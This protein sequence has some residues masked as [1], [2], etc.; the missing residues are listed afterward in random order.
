MET[1]QAIL[2]RRSIRAYE[3]R[4]IPDEELKAILEAGL[5]APSGTNLQPWYFAAIRSPEQMKTLTDIMSGVANKIEPN[6]RQRFAKNPAVVEETTAFVRRLG[7]APVC[8]LVFEYKPHYDNIANII[9]LSLGAAMEN[10]LLA[11]ADR[12]IGG[13]WLTAP[14]EAEVGTLLQETFA[15]GKGPLV[16]LLTLGYPAKAGKAPPRKDGRYIIL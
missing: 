8:V 10:I 6:L 3:P 13:C 2:R 16:S 14:V 9:P 7:G 4:A 1:M 5:W 11:A 12:G 15:P